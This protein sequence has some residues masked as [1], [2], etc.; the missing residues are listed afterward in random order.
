[1]SALP[2]KPP[3]RPTVR[4]TRDGTGFKVPPA[5]LKNGGTFRLRNATAFSV[6]FRIDPALHPFG[7]QTLLQEIAA[8]GVLTR[9]VIW[10]EPLPREFPYQVAVIPKTL[11]GRKWAKGN[12]DPRI[13]IDR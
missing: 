6:V 3:Q 13:I 7:H 12:S 2:R 8:G 4:L 5:R 1:M 11:A 9:T 10:I